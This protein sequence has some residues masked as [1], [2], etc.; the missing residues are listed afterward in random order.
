MPRTR[1]G[2]RS[3]S[4]TSANG[5]LAMRVPVNLF[6]NGRVAMPLK[7]LVR[8]RLVVAVGVL[9]V[10]GAGGCG[11]RALKELHACWADRRVLALT[12]TEGV[13]LPAS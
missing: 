7:L 11:A 3:L 5:L 13:I 8:R 12:R 2:V 9:Q 6:I 1:A 4:A 10:S